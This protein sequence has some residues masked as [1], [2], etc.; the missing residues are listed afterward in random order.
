MSNVSDGKHLKICAPATYHIEV[1]GVIGKSLAD[2]FGAMRLTT[3]TRKDNSIVTI[4]VGGVRD[5]AE[6]SGVLNSLYDYH[7][8]ILSVK[9]LDD[10]E[11]NQ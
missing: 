5:Q 1:E 7:L 4:L 8:P 2:R 10:E 6:L 3:R 11:D 9:L